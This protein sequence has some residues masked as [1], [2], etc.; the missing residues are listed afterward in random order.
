MWSTAEVESE[1]KSLQSAKQA[2]PRAKELKANSCRFDANPQ[3]P[4]AALSE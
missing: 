4:P 2:L 1:G 3:N